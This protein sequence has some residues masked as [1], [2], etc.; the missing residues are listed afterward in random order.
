VAEAY[1]KAGFRAE[2]LSFVTDMPARYRWADLALCRA[3]AL[4]VA[5]L[6]LAGLPALLVPY[7]FAADD[8]QRANARE[9][10]AAGAARALD[11]K[12]LDGASLVAEFRTI[13]SDPERLVAMSRACAALGR[14]DAAARIVAECRAMLDGA[15]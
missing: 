9:L 10:E 4:T 12:R 6:A 8:H 3:G 2:V 15:R 5:E 7:P 11:P 13:G 1:R 14:P